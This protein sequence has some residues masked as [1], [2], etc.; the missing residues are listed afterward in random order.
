MGAKRVAIDS[1]TRTCH[2]GAHELR[3]RP[4]LA[5][6]IRRHLQG[7]TAARATKERGRAQP[8]DVSGLRLDDYADRRA[9]AAWPSSRTPDSMARARIVA[10][11]TVS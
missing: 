4:R 11:G 9:L 8:V 7:A 1:V 3:P 10:S 2:D 6:S 5:Q